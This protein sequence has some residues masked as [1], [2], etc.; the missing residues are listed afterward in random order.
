M[1]LGI[2]HRNLI[3]QSRKDNNTPR[4]CPSLGCNGTMLR[5]Q[6]YCCLGVDENLGCI[7]SLNP[8]YQQYRRGRQ[9]V[10]YGVNDTGALTYNVLWYLGTGGVHA[11]YAWNHE[12]ILARPG[13]GLVTLKRGLKTCI[14][15]RRHRSLLDYNIPNDESGAHSAKTWC[16]AGLSTVSW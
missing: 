10:M 5:C 15:A 1:P 6:I 7:P 3:Y 16:I 12:C 9:A 2:K 13:R 8:L 14:R 4:K 11:A